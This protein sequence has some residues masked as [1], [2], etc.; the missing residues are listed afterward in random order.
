MQIKMFAGMI[1]VFAGMIL[2]FVFLRSEFVAW[3]TLKRKVP[4]EVA[5]SIMSW[6]ISQTSM[7]TGT[8]VA[9]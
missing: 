7:E 4:D 3:V 8:D 9:K 6:F 1:G 2:S 5:T